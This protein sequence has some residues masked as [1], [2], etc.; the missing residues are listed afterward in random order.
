MRAQEGILTV[1]MKRT[2]PLV[3]GSIVD[4][5]TSCTSKDSVLKR[6]KKEN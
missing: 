3:P 6:K 5:A 2:Q 1:K 4:E